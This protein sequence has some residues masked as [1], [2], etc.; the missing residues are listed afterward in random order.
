MSATVDQRPKLPR[1]ISLLTGKDVGIKVQGNL[2]ALVAEALL[3]DVWRYAG[4]QQEAGT[5]MPKS[6][7]RDG[8]HS[9]DGQEPRVLALPQ[10][11]DAQGVAQGV[12]PAADRGPVLTEHQAV[13][14]EL[15]AVSQFQ[16]CLLALVSP[17]ECDRLSCEVDGASPLPFR[18]HEDRVTP[19]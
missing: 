14:V 16:R 8:L 9:G 18:R 5:R 19:A 11:V 2:D 12:A 1:R 13:V 7:Q 15:T 3:H 6:M 10:I 17:E 4:R